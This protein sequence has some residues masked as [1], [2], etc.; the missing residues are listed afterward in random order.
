MKVDMK[1]AIT[2]YSETFLRKKHLIL[3]ATLATMVAMTL[4]KAFAADP[5]GAGIFA[6]DTAAKAF[7]AVNMTWT[8]IMG[9]LV[10]FMQ[11]GFAFLGAGMLRSKAQVNYWSKS[12]IDFSIGVVVFALIGFAFMFGGSGNTFPGFNDAKGNPIPIPGL[13]GGN[14]FIG[15]SGFGLAGDAYD[16]VTITYFFFEAVFAATSVTIVAGMVAERL[17]FQAYLLYTILINIFIYPVYGHWMWGNGWL[18]TLPFGVGARDFAGSGVVHAVGGF[19]GLAGAFL[20]GPRIGKYNKDG[21]PNSFPAHNIPYMFAGTFVLFFGWF[22]FN[23]GSTLAATDYRISV[24]AVNTYL[25]GGMAA[26]VNAYLTYIIKRKSDPTAIANGAL[27]GL[28]AITA[29]CAYVAPWAAIVI[30]AIA[31]PLTVYGNKFAERS[32]KIDDAVGAWGVH[33]ASGLWGLL[34]I[35]IFADGTYGGG[36]YNGVDYSGVTGILYGPLGVGQLIAQLIDIVVVAGFAFGMGLVIFGAIKATMG[37]RV[38]PEV[39][40]AGLDFHEHEYV[41]YPELQIFDMPTGDEME[42]RREHHVEM[43]PNVG[44]RKSVVP[45]PIQRDEKKSA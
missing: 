29:P 20:L 19:T 6:N 13:E 31:G 35:G 1:Y 14:Q 17:K 11:L 44:D 22:G 7:L 12:Y 30:G 28:V 5:S 26:A 38:S 3:L 32:L 18:A 27:G 15:W 39:E 45:A 43:P 41:A 33:G 23:P 10:W 16:V 42:H 24:I 21:T 25:S 40:L 36:K 37:L 9:A 34:S 8:I 2:K 4:G